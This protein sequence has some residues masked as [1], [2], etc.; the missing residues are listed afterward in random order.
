LV[1]ERRLPWDSADDHVAAQLILTF[2]IFFATIFVLGFVAEPLIAVCMD[3]WGS[4]FGLFN[5]FSWE[6]TWADDIGYRD[7][8]QEDHDKSWT[9]HFTMGFASLG[10]LSM[11]KTML[12]SPVQIWFRRSGRRGPASGR[13]R[14]S[15]LSWL[16]I[17]I[18][19]ATFIYVRSS[20]MWRVD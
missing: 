10:L 13:D 15:N 8:V 17:L 9:T 11:A 19:A 6:P 4:I 16:M 1:S 2:L 5:F 3:P 7:Y 12:T 20:T 14:L 18:G